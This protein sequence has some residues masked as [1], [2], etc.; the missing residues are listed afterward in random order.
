M[1]FYRFSIE[2]SRILPNGDVTNI[3]EKGIEH[4]N[5]IIDKLLELS[6]EPMIT[7]YNSDLP[8]TFQKLG[9]F[10]NSII[11]YYFEAYAN[12]LFERFGDRV[13]YW[14]TFNKPVQ[15]C[16]NGYGGVDCTAAMNLSG[17]G[18]YLCVHNV[19]KAHAVAYHLYK[20]AFFER[21]RGQIGLTVNVQYMYS[22]D[23]GLV[24]RAMDFSV[25]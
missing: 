8:K 2:W 7:M 25:C 13:K 9:G 18:E 3:N 4:Y 23:L 21:F 19:L 20:N 15:F 14:I 16:L 1:N 17:I 10:T 11:I 6:I 22:D 12:L 5:R 24:D